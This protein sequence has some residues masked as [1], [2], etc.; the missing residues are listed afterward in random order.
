[1]SVSSV[2]DHLGY[3]SLDDAAPKDQD[4]ISAVAQRAIHE[5]GY[6][7]DVESG[8]PSPVF[9]HFKE[10]QILRALDNA[11]KSSNFELAQSEF[12]KFKT[13]QGKSLDL[14]EKGA[15]KFALACLQEGKERLALVAM[16]GLSKEAVRDVC[17][18]AFYLLGVV[19]NRI[20]LCEE[21]MLL[22]STDDVK[23]I[24]F[25][26]LMLINT[27]SIN[28]CFEQAM[29]QAPYVMDLEVKKLAYSNIISVLVKCPD[30][31]NV[32]ADFLARSVFFIE[33]EE[34][35]ALVR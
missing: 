2:R 23:E 3:L 8:P 20:S 33:D 35:L 19:Q 12:E 7:A 5:A 24:D 16:T 1:M 22:Y 13:V 9:T 29:F 6:F 31:K 17:I 21:L 32:A 11:L 15:T 14:Y 18:N 28:G 25:R 26:R 10:K 34:L 27:L 4:S 30:G